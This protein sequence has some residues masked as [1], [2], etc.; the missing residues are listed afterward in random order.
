[1]LPLRSR[2]VRSGMVT[3]MIQRV[4]RRTA[5]ARIWSHWRACGRRNRVRAPLV[6]E[7]DINGSQYTPDLGGRAYAVI[8]PDLGTGLASLRRSLLPAF[9]LSGLAPFHLSGF[10]LCSSLVLVGLGV[11]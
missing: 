6:E 1:M 7:K 11:G 2:V 3:A 10:G 4:R 9:I 5:H 8:V